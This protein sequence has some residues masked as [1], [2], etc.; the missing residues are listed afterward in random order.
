MR[1]QEDGCHWAALAARQW[2]CPGKRG[3]IHGFPGKNGEN[4]WFSRENLGHPMM[5][6]SGNLRFWNTKRRSDLRT[7]N[8]RRADGEFI[9]TR[10]IIFASMVGLTW[11][12]IFGPRSYRNWLLTTTMLL[13][14]S[15]YKL[16]IS[17]MCHDVS[18][19]RQAARNQEAQ[20][21][22][23]LK[24]SFIHASFGSLH[25]TSPGVMDNV[26]CV[27]VYIY[28]YVCICI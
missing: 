14:S 23:R 12:N 16:P 21:L 5:R 27:C 1:I 8:H 7:F 18:G 17:I 3:K 13:R 10:Y 6:K 11:W 26:Q 19:G 15:S 2:R 9:D 24:A 22:N 20:Y 28:I 25:V 4:P